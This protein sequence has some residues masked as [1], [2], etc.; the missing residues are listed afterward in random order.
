MGPL[1]G[2]WA[3]GPLPGRNGMTSIIK[4]AVVSV[5]DT[6]YAN[7]Q[8]WHIKLKRLSLQELHQS[9]VQQD[10]LYSPHLLFLN[11]ILFSSSWKHGTA[12]RMWP[13][14]RNQKLALACRGSDPHFPCKTN[15]PCMRGRCRPPTIPMV[16]YR[17]PSFLP[18]PATVGH[19]PPQA[20][21]PR[22]P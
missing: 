21:E 18:Q 7:L 5:F 11:L 10:V 16:L 8:I 3:L 9:S 14:G 1:V 20:A 13:Y 4:W 2:P 6:C 19:R 15:S 17:G 12:A 22:R